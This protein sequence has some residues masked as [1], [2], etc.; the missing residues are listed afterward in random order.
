MGMRKGFSRSPEIN[1]TCSSAPSG[2]YGTKGLTSRELKPFITSVDQVEN[3]L[4]ANFGIPSLEGSERRTHNDRSALTIEV[5]RREQV[6]H[7]HV[8]EFEHF[9]VRDLVNLVD[10]NDEPLDTDL[11][12]QKQ[13]LPGLGHLSIRSRNNDNSAIHLS[14]TSNH[15]LDVYRI[16]MSQSEY[17]AMVCTERSQE[18]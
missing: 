9:R 13:M 3:L 18:A 4:L 7:F 11:T 2:D 6:A 10:E 8:H 15:V 16:E 17:D 1:N 5:V 14:R 12:S